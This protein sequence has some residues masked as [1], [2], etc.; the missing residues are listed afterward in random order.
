VMRSRAPAETRPVASDPQPGQGGT[1]ERSELRRAGRAA[2]LDRL[3]ELRRRMDAL[4]RPRE[5]TTEG[6]LRHPRFQGLRTDQAPAD[7]L[8]EGG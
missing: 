7:V 3:T 2:P 4:E 6:M 8:C 5:W 1:R